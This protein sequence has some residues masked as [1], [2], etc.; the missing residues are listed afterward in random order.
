MKCPFQPIVRK[1]PQKNIRGKYAS[2]I[3]NGMILHRNWLEYR[4]IKHDV[5]VGMY[6]V[7][8]ISIYCN[9]FIL[10]LYPSLVPIIM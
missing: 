3:L 9:Y 4:E 10:I 2:L 6:I 8:S 7:K 5:Y 1:F